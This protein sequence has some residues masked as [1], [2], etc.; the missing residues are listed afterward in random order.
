MSNKPLLLS[1]HADGN[2]IATIWIMM[3][4]I[5]RANVG[6]IALKR[7]DELVKSVACS[8][9][10]LGNGL[11]NLEVLQ[12]H[13]TLGPTLFLTQRTHQHVAFQTQIIVLTETEID[14]LA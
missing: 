12:L 10:D 13:L 2:Y 11:R 14:D 4:K 6:S 8:I 3:K 7:G 1:V 5:V 9:K